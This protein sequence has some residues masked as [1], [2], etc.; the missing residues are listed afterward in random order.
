MN[1][2]T[3]GYAHQLTA[4]ERSVGRNQF[5]M[6]MEQGTGKCWVTLAE[7]CREY[8]G[9]VSSLVVVAPKGV[10]LNWKDEIELHLE[11]GVEG[12]DL[13]IWS[14]YRLKADNAVLARHLTTTAV[15]P[16]VL[17]INVETLSV[18]KKNVKKNIGVPDVA[19][20]SAVEY[21]ELYLEA[22]QSLL[23]VDESTT[24]KYH[25]SARTK[26][27]V[28]ISP[29]ARMRRILS[30][31]PVPKSPVDL[32]GQCLFLGR[33]LLPY[34]SFRAFEAAHVIKET[35]TFG[36]RAFKKV[37]GFKNIDVLTKITDEFTYRV[38][39]SECLDLPL[40]VYESRSVELTPEQV[41]M[42]NTLAAK[43]QAE[44][45]SGEIVTA[46]DA[47]TRS[48]R[49][50]QIVCGHTVVD[51][52]EGEP[53]DIIDLPSNRY[54]ALKEWIDSNDSAGIIWANL[55]EDYGDDSVVEYWGATSKEDREIAR[56]KFQAGEV[57]FFVGNPH[58]AGMGLTLTKAEW[59]VYYSNSHNLEHRVQSEDRCHRIGLKHSVTY[60]D[61]IAR[62]TVDER[63]LAG[64]RLKKEV[65]GTVLGDNPKEWNTWFAPVGKGMIA[66]H[67]RDDKTITPASGALASWAKRKVRH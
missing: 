56:K 13:V 41:Q 31:F 53:G 12:V 24:I 5:G 9:K 16:R 66:K 39:K 50:H 52:D 8:G 64:L 20:M 49:L 3:T 18:K 30:G 46:I 23:V 47:M 60:V 10:Y 59:A 27:V 11:G 58:V 25:K 55:K 26:N 22:N 44:V 4:L 57:R 65:G 34:G 51:N 14:S 29:L 67:I 33:G 36:P 15:V 35:V 61:L 21:L 28:Q 6:F 48:T 32:W 42:Y 17:L 7:F 40:K 45:A 38:L 54:G 63:I 19:K 62:G 2:A 37:V 43:F 1:M